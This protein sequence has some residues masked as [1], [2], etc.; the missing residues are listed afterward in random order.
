MMNLRARWADEALFACPL[1]SSPCSSRGSSSLRPP[2]ARHELE[3][4]ATVAPRPTAR[5][6]PQSDR[7][8]VDTP[9]GAR[10]TTSTTTPVRFSSS[11]QNFEASN[12]SYDDEL[13][14]DFV[15][16][17]GV[18]WNIEMV[19]VGGEYF[20]GPGPRTA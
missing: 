16:P 17:G 10:S 4:R 8:A 15:V 7:P 3:L 14:D 5:S 9:R 18:G 6:P 20:N 12:N 11:S 13:A 2:A 1:A 19:E